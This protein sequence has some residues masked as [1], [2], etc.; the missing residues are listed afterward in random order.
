MV[1]RL[2]VRH[3]SRQRRQRRGLRFQL[4]LQGLFR[5]PESHSLAAQLLCPAALFAQSGRP[6]SRSFTGDVP[7]VGRLIELTLQTPEALLL[8][9]S[10][11]RLLGC[12]GLNGS[13]HQVL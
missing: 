2:D 5:P 3:S 10:G 9:L 8:G 11:P 1:E 6:R 12:E 7:L 4:R 13:S